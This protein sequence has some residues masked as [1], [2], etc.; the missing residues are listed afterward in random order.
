MI[1]RVQ[2]LVYEAVADLRRR[3]EGAMPPPK[4]GNSD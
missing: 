2:K 4:G 1:M 3:A